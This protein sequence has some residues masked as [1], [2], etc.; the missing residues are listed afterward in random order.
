MIAMLSGKI[1]YKGISHVVVD[2]QGVG[3][4]VFIP[5]TTFYALPEADQAIT[6]HIH[7]SVKEDAIHLFGFYT[8]EERE[9]FQLMISVSGIGPKVAL[10]IL[11]GIS[12]AELL[13]AISAGNL[14]RLMAIPGIGR[15]MAERLI[16]ELKEKVM[17]KMAADAIPAADA[18][19]KQAEMMREDALSALM[20]LGYK[21]G[22]ARDALEKAARDLK[23]EP[24]MDQLL[25]KALKILAG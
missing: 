13:E 2:A 8:R 3:Y 25:K 18:K 16:L 5:L 19:Q 17:K 20:N 22:A 7:T 1:A 24:A 4:R 10:N 21:A 23:E 15:K 12:S 14:T 11:S 9:L 6:L